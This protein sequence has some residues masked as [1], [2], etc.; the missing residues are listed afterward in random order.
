MRQRTFTIC[1][2]YYGKVFQMIETNYVPTY[3][4]LNYTYLVKVNFLAFTI[5]P[6]QYYFTMQA[7]SYYLTTLS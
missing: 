7:S 2:S 5:L 4:K 1:C 6:I 3:V